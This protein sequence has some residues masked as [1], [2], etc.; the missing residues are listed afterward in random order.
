[1]A[2]LTYPALVGEEVSDQTEYEKLLFTEYRKRR[3]KHFF[4]ET[5]F[6]MDSCKDYLAFAETVYREFLEFAGKPKDYELWHTRV[7]S[8]VINNKAEWECLMKHRNKNDPP[9]ILEKK[10]GPERLTGQEPFL[11]CTDTGIGSSIPRLS[12]AL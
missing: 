2:W 4:L 1:M 5:S 11:P 12:Q 3:N 9:H 10:P 7:H 6:D 8:T